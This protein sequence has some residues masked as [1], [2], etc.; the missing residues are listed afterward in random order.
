MI[1][2]I[3]YYQV[4]GVPT[5]AKAKA[6]EKAY[7]KKVLQLDRQSSHAQSANL[8]E[9]FRNT[10]EAYLVL[11]NHDARQVFDKL[12][13]LYR[14]DDLIPGATTTQVQPKAT[15]IAGVLSNYLHSE[16]YTTY[17]QHFSE[18][19][20]QPEAQKRELP[21]LADF[22]PKKVLIGAATIAILA[23][24]ARLINPGPESIQDII[25]TFGKATDFEKAHLAELVS[26]HPEAI[27]AKEVLLAALTNPQEEI[28]VRSAA[29]KSLAVFAGQDLEVQNALI[30]AVN[31]PQAFLRIHATT[32][33]GLIK[34]P[35]AAITQTLFLGLSDD[36]EQVRLASSV[37]IANFGTALVEKNITTANAATQ[38][39]KSAEPETAPVDTLSIETALGDLKDPEPTVRIAA[40]H[41]LE[42]NSELPQ[43]AADQLIAMLNDTDSSVVAAA[44]ETIGFLQNDK[45]IWPLLSLLADQDQTVRTAVATA[46]NKMPREKVELALSQV[47]KGEFEQ[48]NASELAPAAIPPPPQQQPEEVSPIVLASAPP[49]TA[50][51]ELGLG[52][53]PRQ[54]P[55]QLRYRNESVESYPDLQRLRS[56]A[57]A[58]A[59]SESKT[60]VKAQLAALPL[61]LENLLLARTETPPLQENTLPGPRSL[62]LA[63]LTTRDETIPSPVAS[64]PDLTQ[65]SIAKGSLTQLAKL[66]LRSEE[67]PNPK[68]ATPHLAQ[69]SARK[70]PPLQLAQLTLR[71]EVI[72]NPQAAT[73][74]LAPTDTRKVA[75]TQLAKL[76]VISEPI[77]EVTAAVTQ[78]TPQVGDTAIPAAI[79]AALGVNA[80]DSIPWE[81]AVKLTKAKLGQTNHNMALTEL[82]QHPNQK[83]QTL[84]CFAIA[85]R[86]AA[87]QAELLAIKQL[88][89]SNTPQIQAAAA[90]AL[91]EIPGSAHPE[92]E[93]RLGELV[94]S[95]NF[96]VNMHAARALG[97]FGT[98]TAQELLKQQN[99]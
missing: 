10:N 31:S 62:E 90:W 69:D 4:L 1:R 52:R 49:L 98:A 16:F 91:A 87:S 99:G 35:S 89:N 33:L 14:H 55:P 48:L 74:E 79:A 44:A 5:D 42:S 26:K 54:L 38:S 28:V 47:P 84:A 51:P 53:D 12:G 67:I 70:A 43:H 17:F 24:T 65:D 56:E 37:A 20:P 97:R 71:S 23:L 94:K 30:E 83:L 73:P 95:K 27:K 88:L 63:K 81:Q 36:N 82:L 80:I 41:A 15:S 72:P 46:L 25:H 68:S 32:A 86:G 57:I 59:T 61:R 11:L 22:K 93:R 78:P 50:D 92:T 45:A 19:S 85:Q 66:A 96:W 13:A 2:F 64:A 8:I 6:I 76:T 29:A 75:T 77:P 3:D 9:L 60:L 58:I 40:I 34:T 18:R 21:Q 39:D 7:R